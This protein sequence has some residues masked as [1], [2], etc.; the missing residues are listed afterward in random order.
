MR[1]FPFDKA[2]LPRTVAYGHAAA[3]FCDQP[4]LL[5]A[6]QAQV[7]GFR[8]QFDAPEY[9]REKVCFDLDVRLKSRP[10]GEL[11]FYHPK[12]VSISAG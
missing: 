7:Q 12:A 5:L 9:L 2:W 11:R 1:D 3:D 8:L 10:F 6:G 4:R